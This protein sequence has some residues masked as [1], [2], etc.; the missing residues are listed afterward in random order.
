MCLSASCFFSERMVPFEETNELD[1]D[2]RARGGFDGCGGVYYP[3]TDGV[4][5]KRGILSQPARLGG[6][7]CVCVKKILLRQGLL[8]TLRYVVK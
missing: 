8:V 5:P 4:W 1:S 2:C 6:R 3:Q 7:F